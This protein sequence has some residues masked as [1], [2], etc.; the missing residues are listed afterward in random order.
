VTYL[1]RGTVLERYGS[2]ILI[3]G[4]AYSVDKAMR[5]PHLSW[6]PQEEI[7]VADEV[8]CEAA[9]KV[10]VVLSHDAPN[11]AYVA[12]LAQI[13][14]DA[15]QTHLGWKCDER[16]PG[17]RPNRM[18][19]EA[20]L[21]ACRPRLWVH[22]HYHQHYVAQAKDCQFIGLDHENMPGSWYILEY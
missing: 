15:Q 14:G 20:I 17:A 7:T 9:G 1:P 8:R 21:D 6:W 19:L 4:G 18:A 16:F 12:A 11:S 3:I 10:D 5:S 22:G 2:R 13:L